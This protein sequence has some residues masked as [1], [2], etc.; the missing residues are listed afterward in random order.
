MH[1]NLQQPQALKM[2]T[3]LNRSVALL[4][5]RLIAGI[6]FFFQA[7]DKIFKLGVKNVI[8]TFRESLSGTFL[9]G[10]ILASAV[11]ASSY[12][13][14]GF[15]ALLMTGIY[16]S[17]VLYILG[18]DLLIVALVFSLIKPM[19]DMQFFF[20]RLILITILLLC[21]PEWD[22]FTLTLLF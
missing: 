1:L 13:E 4:I 17:Y 7:Y 3:E 2:E 14:L 18:I 11:Y 21:P 5:I 19:W 20:P 12:L 10:G 22:Q 15:G 6:L 8:W 16:K 9:K